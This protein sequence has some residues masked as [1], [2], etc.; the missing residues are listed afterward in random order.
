MK[1]RS[2]VNIP[3]RICKNPRLESKFVEEAEKEG[4]KYLAGFKGIGCRASLYNG[5]PVEGAEKL[6]RF[7]K[8]FK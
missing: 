7:M 4:L 5:M 8:R 6:A 2:R 1:F 3:F